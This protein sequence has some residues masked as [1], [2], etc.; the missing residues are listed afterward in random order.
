[1]NLQEVRSKYPQYADMSDEQLGR[2]LHNKFYSDM[3]YEEFAAKAGI[4][5]AATQ[6]EAPKPLPANAGLANFIA[7]TVGLPMDTVQNVINLTRAAQGGV[8]GAVG[9]TDWMPQLMEN[10]PGGSENIK[11][12][13]RR[14]GQPGLSPDNP[15]PQDPNAVRQFN[16]VSRGG[17]IPGGAIPAVAAQIAEET[18]G[19]EWAGPASLTPAA[20]AQAGRNVKAAVADPQTVQQN[21]ETAKRAGT[22][23][24]VAQATENNFLR[25]LTNVISRFPGGQGI[26]TKFRENQ[27]E[28]LGAAARTGVSAEKA[29]RA[30]KEGVAAEG[31]FLDRTKATWQQLDYELSQKVGGATLA[32]S[33]T[34]AALDDLTSTSAGAERTTAS[35]VN[36]RL[37]KMRDDLAADMA[38]NNGQI[39]F[40]A[41]R[42]L[43]SRVGAMLD[44]SLVSGIPNG[45]LKKVYGG[46]S[47]DLEEAAR[48]AGAGK[49]FDRQANFYS[50]RQ[51][52]IENTLDRVLGNKEYEDIFK[53]VAPTDVDS[54]NKVRRVFR[55][56][57]PAQRQIVS[58]AIVNRM[59]RATPG[60]QDVTGEKFSSGTFLTNWSRINDSAKAQLFPDEVM[61]N[62]VDAIA[63]MSSE[64]RDSRTPFANP[65]GTAQ[66]LTAAGVY[67][68]PFVSLSTGSVTPMAIA[69][70]MVAGANIGAR[71]L[72]N[73]KVVD[74]LAK[75]GKVTTDE[76]MTAHL[77]RLAVIY[78]QTQD[79]ALKNEL[80]EYIN[81]VK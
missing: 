59:G 45:E 52:R 39:P 3:P 35:L 56:L 78:N 71:M 67:S 12:M 9:A 27:Q 54:V 14:T 41:L 80:G 36:P 53:G 74:W 51:E 76:Q 24:D 30:I 5:A 55:S 8:A 44:D 48:K 68:S 75:A 81:S 15:N 16:Q 32:P 58:E 13:L 46:I 25:G 2:A 65:S 37:Q 49:E 73:P 70:S 77:G 17:F 22:T 47:K 23:P 10:I 79:Q 57:D 62:K 29:G 50:A 20:I 61:R 69:G 18:L 31:G 40:E 42:T 19:P 28:Q 21:V 26:I 72:T 60:Q 34:V 11:N 43:R 38:A 64:I 1:M 33:K 6:P 4:K 7:S 66:G 63:K